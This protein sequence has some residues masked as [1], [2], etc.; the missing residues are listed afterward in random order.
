MEF[1]YD[2]N[3]DLQFS[4]CRAEFLLF[5]A[6]R[7]LLPSTFPLFLRIPR[8]CVVLSHIVTALP[9]QVIV[10]PTHLHP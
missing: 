10:I 9:S 3:Q 7:P 1:S 2:L 5:K 8:S 4:R 6:M